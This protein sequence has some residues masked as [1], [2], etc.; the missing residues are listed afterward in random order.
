MVELSAGTAIVGVA[1]AGTVVLVLLGALV[2]STRRWRSTVGRLATI[3]TR[4]EEPGDGSAADADVVGR[5]ERQAQSAV[6]R[7]SD[8]AARAERLAG[9]LA[10]VGVGV[11]VCDEHGDVAF[12][13][14]PAARYEDSGPVAA[15]VAEVLGESVG[16]A[17]GRSRTVEAAGPPWRTLRVTGH[18]L[19]DGRRVVGGM[20]VIEDVSEGRRL[21]VVRRDFLAN[22]T[23]ELGSPV[24]ALGLLAGTIVAEDDATLTRRLAARLERD[25]IRVARI[26]DDLAELSR[27]EAEILPPRQVV[28]VNLLVAQAVEQARAAG[29]PER[30]VR[31]DVSGSPGDLVV[32]GDRRQLVSALRRL[33][34]NALCHSDAGSGVS[35]TVSCA[36][37]W[38]EVAVVDEGPGIPADEL[39][40]VFESFYRVGPDRARSPA[41]SGLGLAIASR[42]AGAHRGRVDVASTAGGGSTFSLRLP[43]HREGGPVPARGGGR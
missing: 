43:A 1:V 10:H 33:V 2:R 27:L 8:E 3:T 14:P 16:D 24:A 6:L 28:P 5:L 37:E 4:L 11:V 39:D 41:G 29:G 31:I 12:R 34:E 26:V 20:A 13:N 38:V 19:D 15:A 30:A 22:V 36:D 25:A 42:A 18:P 35:V 40:R 32:V 9:A 21:D 23:A 17:G 7:L